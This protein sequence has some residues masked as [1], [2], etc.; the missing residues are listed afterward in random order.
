MCV[1]ELTLSF[2]QAD[3]E[4]TEILLPQH[5]IKDVC[6]TTSRSLSVSVLPLQLGSAAACASVAGSLTSASCMPACAAAAAATVPWALLTRR[7]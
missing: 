4:L 6:A 7:W 3:S 2:D 1:L 5:L